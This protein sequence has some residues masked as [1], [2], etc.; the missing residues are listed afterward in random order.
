MSSPMPYITGL[1]VYSTFANLCFAAM[2]LWLLWR[3]RSV[4][5]RLSRVER[6]LTIAELGDE[7]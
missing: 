4:T 7:T 1:V 2:V 6:R 3:L 5:K